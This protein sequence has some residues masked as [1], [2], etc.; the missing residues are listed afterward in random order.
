MNQSKSDE[1]RSRLPRLAAEMDEAIAVALKEIRTAMHI[2]EQTEGNVGLAW[3]KG[4]ADALILLRP[5][6]EAH[7]QFRKWLAEVVEQEVDHCGL[8]LEER[9]SLAGHTN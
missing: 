8:T 6:Q 4:L 1:L 7:Q 2:A 3:K 5:A 9:R